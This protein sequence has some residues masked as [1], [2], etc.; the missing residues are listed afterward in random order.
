MRTIRTYLSGCDWCVAVGE[1]DNPVFNPTVTGSTLKITCPVCHGTKTILITEIEEK[2][3]LK[4][5][6]VSIKPITLGCKVRM[7]PEWEDGINKGR[8]YYVN[9]IKENTKT[10]FLRWENFTEKTTFWISME[11]VEVI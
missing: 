11:K 9:I 8:I 7:K 3:D 2:E 5:E 1:I 10:V 4:I 6:G